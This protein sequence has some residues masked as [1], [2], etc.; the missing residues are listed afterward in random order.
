M[1]RTLALI[2]A[3]AITLVAPGA[4]E[5]HAIIVASVPAPQQTV[6]GPDLMIRLNF[7]SRIDP[8]RSRVTLEG[9]G[10]AVRDMP[11]APD[12]EPGTITGLGRDLTAG[13]WVLKWQVLSVDGH[14][15]RGTIPF[16]VD[17]NLPPP[18][19]GMAQ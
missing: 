17:P 14:I 8:D 7:N 10:G 1:F 9:P 5:A 12:T 19:D 6:R 13:A 3:L 2:A 18:S 4:A 11:I 15:T 16:T